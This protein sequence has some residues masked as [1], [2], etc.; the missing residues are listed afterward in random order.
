MGKFREFALLFTLAA[1]TLAATQGIS[2]GTPKKGV[3][4]QEINTPPQEPSS[5]NTERPPS[6]VTVIVRQETAPPDNANKEQDDEN[7]R[8][9]RKIAVFTAFLVLVGLIQA[10]IL[11]FTIRAVNRQTA[12]NQHIERAWVMAELRVSPATSLLT[13]TS[14]YQGTTTQTTSAMGLRLYCVNDG[15]SPAWITEKSARLV[16]VRRGDL[17]R[18]PE[19]SRED[20]L[21]DDLEPMGPGKDNV[22]VWDINGKGY[23]SIDT[24][25]LVY[26]VVR[27]TDIF[28]NK[29][30]T[31][32]C[33]QLTGYKNSRKVIRV[34]GELE[35]NKNT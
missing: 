13:G 7:I 23:H 10:A 3:A 30:E 35:Y 33:Y 34:T 1:I 29:R 2:Q 21:A 22:F 12:T 18:F 28:K 27:Y 17:P 15:N 26:G 25:T 20:I 14:T 8:I 6:P 5:A 4:K 19:L 9:Q 31:W 24:A 11:W 16:V 32:F